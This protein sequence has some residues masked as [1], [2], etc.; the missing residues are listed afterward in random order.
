VRHRE[1]VLCVVTIGLAVCCHP[2]TDSDRTPMGRVPA[3]PGSLVFNDSGFRCAVGVPIEL[4][5]GHTVASS[6]VC[7]SR[8]RDTSYVVAY[9]VDHRPILRMTTWSVPDRAVDSVVSALSLTL[10]KER[11]AGH[12]CL[13]RG[14]ER[15]WGTPPHNLLLTVSR[16]DLPSLL[17][18]MSL[19]EEADVP[20]C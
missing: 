8:K 4:A 3:L 18:S 5:S 2:G 15:Y 16:P 6:Q 13:Q 11:G 10:D 9:T 14:I 20:N 19:T 12:Q 1:A 17:A 7:V